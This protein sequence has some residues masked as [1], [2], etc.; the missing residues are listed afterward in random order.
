MVVKARP[1]YSCLVKTRIFTLECLFE[2]YH[3]SSVVTA[4]VAILH[5]FTLVNIS[6]ELTGQSVVP[7]CVNPEAWF[8]V[9]N[10]AAEDMLLAA[11]YQ[12]RTSEVLKYL[13]CHLCMVQDMGIG[14][15]GF[16]IYLA[17]VYKMAA[18]YDAR[19]WTWKET[20]QL[21]RDFP[22]GFWFVIYSAEHHDS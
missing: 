15:F 3:N 4:R 12:S 14:C 10:P 11:S 16:G 19:D 18:D 6:R 7:Q 5:M 9:R 20:S 8:S 21:H 1:L 2:T 17:D 22:G 13:S